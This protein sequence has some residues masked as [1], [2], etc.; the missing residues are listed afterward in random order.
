MLR[1]TCASYAQF[2]SHRNT[3]YV[4]LSL[5]VH[6]L[7]IG[8]KRSPIGVLRFALRIP[9]IA[10]IGA[11]RYVLAIRVYGLTILLSLTNYCYMVKIYNIPSQLSSIV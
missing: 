7:L 9:R 4:V 2:V 5:L 1:A 6:N 10:P 11:P 8:V 3:S